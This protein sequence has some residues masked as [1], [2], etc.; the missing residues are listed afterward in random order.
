MSEPAV[1]KPTCMFLQRDGFIWLIAMHWDSRI[2]GHVDGEIL[3]RYEAAEVVEK[4]LGSDAKKAFKKYR[5]L[6][7]D[8]EGAPDPFEILSNGKPSK[9]I[10]GSMVVF[11]QW[12]PEDKTF[13]IQGAYARTGT[14]HVNYK[15]LKP[16]PDKTSDEAL[17]EVVLAEF[18]RIKKK[19]GI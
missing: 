11:V 15:P 1:V 13:F 9:F 6:R 12:N 5:V 10:K 17:G 19:E 18:K 16:L 7:G 4:K 3:I 2:D 14:R 8:D